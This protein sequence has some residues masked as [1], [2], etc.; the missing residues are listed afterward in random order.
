MEGVVALLS[1]G[2][3]FEALVR[4]SVLASRRDADDLALNAWERAYARAGG[5]RANQERWLS[6]LEAE[7]EDVDLASVAGEPLSL[8]LAL[9]QLLGAESPE[10]WPF[11]EPFDVDGRAYWLVPM[12]LSRSSKAASAHQRGNLQAWLRHHRVVPAMLSEDLQIRVLP[13]RDVTDSALREVSERGTLS[14]FIA[15]FEDGA[16]LE[17]APEGLFF[18]RELSNDESRRAGALRAIEQATAAASDLLIFPELSLTPNHRDAYVRK[19][20]RAARRRGK[21]PA[22]T[23]PGSF[24]EEIPDEGS[25]SGELRRVNRAVLVGPDGRVILRHAKL[26]IYGDADGLSEDIASASTLEVLVTPIGIVGVL[27]CKD[28]CDAFSPVR[29]CHRIAFVDWWLVPSMGDQKTV[30]AHFRQAESSWK[31]ANRCT[32]VVANQ[33]LAVGDPPGSEAAPEF[34]FDGER[35][36]AEAGGSVITLEIT[37]ISAPALRLVERPGTRTSRL[38]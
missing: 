24:H 4:L 30:S 32:T 19:E 20:L 22:L 34:V 18:V 6:L 23:L 16:T 2:R 37:E 26:R 33:E 36:N 5:S 9:D 35:R 10:R 28:F 12:R 14:A 21:A 3:F 8:L 25:A 31:I 7:N 1:A 27:I 15:H 38:I 11:E 29:D 17:P 13:S